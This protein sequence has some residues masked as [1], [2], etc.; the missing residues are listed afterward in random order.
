MTKDGILS[1]VMLV[2]VVGELVTGFSSS[3]LHF[4]SF[5][6][7]MTAVNQSSEG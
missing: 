1:L 4:I 5:M 7:L 6:A 2:C 3:T